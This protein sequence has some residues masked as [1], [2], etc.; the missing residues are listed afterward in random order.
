MPTPCETKEEVVKWF[1]MMD[2]CHFHQINP[3]D[4]CAWAKAEEAW[5][6]RSAEKAGEAA[7]YQVHDK[8]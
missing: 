6:K 2:Y 5:N 1:W 8:D 7:H 4:S 3:A